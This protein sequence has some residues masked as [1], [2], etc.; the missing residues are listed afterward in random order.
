MTSPSRRLANLAALAVLAALA[1][2]AWSAS[3]CRRLRRHH[4]A[5]VV[6][7]SKKPRSYLHFH[8]VPSFRRD[9]VPYFVRNC[10]QSNECH[11]DKLP[12]AAD[13]DL[14]PEGAY[15]TLIGKETPAR[16]WA[17]RVVPYAPEKSFLV[18]KMTGKLGRFEGHRMPIDEYSKEV[19][20]YD[21]ETRAF[22]ERV[23]VPWIAAGAK[24]DR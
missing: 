24:D 6:A 22:V 20:P 4:G 11:G 21:D 5:H 8:G 14:S 2:L 17:I 18:D 19:L 1:S 3:G 13:L 9:V 23:L 16:A 10:A 12:G 15:R 7:K